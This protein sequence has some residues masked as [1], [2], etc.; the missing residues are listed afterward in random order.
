VTP[1][2][3]LE[4]N[5]GMINKAIKEGKTRAVPKMY[6]GYLFPILISVLSL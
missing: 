3:S 5:P 1:V 4:A 6:H 2:G